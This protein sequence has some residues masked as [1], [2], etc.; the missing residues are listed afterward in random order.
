MLYGVDYS[1]R[2]SK[3]GEGVERGVYICEDFFWLFILPIYRLMQRNLLAEVKEEEGWTRGNNNLEVG[4][5]LAEACSAVC[6]PDGYGYMAG[7]L[8]EVAP[9]VDLVVGLQGHPDLGG[10]K[11]VGASL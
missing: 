1:S 7:G 5:L 4:C 11:L 6:Y 8:E 3:E 10:G 2:R 9:C